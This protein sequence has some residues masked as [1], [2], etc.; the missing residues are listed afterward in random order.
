MALNINEMALKCIPDGGTEECRFGSTN[1]RVKPSCMLEI[2]AKYFVVHSN[3][4]SYTLLLL[5]FK[6]YIITAFLNSAVREQFSTV[7]SM[8][9]Q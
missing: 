7:T 3:I 6:D 9:W 1:Q 5:E 4:A 2:S 8:L